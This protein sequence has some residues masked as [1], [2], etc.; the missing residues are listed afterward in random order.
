MTLND[1]LKQTEAAAQGTS[2]AKMSAATFTLQAWL[3]END[4]Y[5]VTTADFEGLSSE[6]L[7]GILRSFM[8]A[9]AHILK[10][11]SLK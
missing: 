2:H 8:F 7:H 4:G 6:F 9:T 3:E 1:V 11:G 10:E 5:V